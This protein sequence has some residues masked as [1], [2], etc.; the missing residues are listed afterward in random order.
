MDNTPEIPST[1]MK[2]RRMGCLLPAVAS[3]L[4]GAWVVRVSLASWNGR[5]GVF[6][7]SGWVEDEQGNRVPDAL[8]EKTTV[9]S[10]VPYTDTKYESTLIRLSDGTFHVEASDVGDLDISAT[11]MGV[12]ITDRFMVKAAGGRPDWLGRNR[13]EVHDV[14]LVLRREATTQL[15]KPLLRS[16]PTR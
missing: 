5:N 2:F 13:V 9:V 4:A 7:V 15:S 10:P 16:S 11:K 12:G 8:L 1:S 6:I 14:R 3:L